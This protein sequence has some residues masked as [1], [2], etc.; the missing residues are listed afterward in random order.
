[1]GE[2]EKGR[3]GE[4]GFSAAETAAEE[5]PSPF[6]PF[7]HSPTLH[8]PSHSIKIAQI[9][10]R[11]DPGGS[12]DVVLALCE[13]LDRA[14]FDV[15][16]VT[17]PGSDSA[18]APPDVAGRV[19]V[20]VT[21]CAGLTREVSAWRDF[22]ALMSLYSYLRRLRPHVVHTH[23]SKAG[24]LGRLAAAW[25][26]IPVVHS[27]HGHLFY[28]YYGALGTELVV[29]AERMLAPYAG[30]IAVL[31]ET[32]RTEHLERGI[33]RMPQYEVVPSGIDLGRFTPDP[34]RRGRMRT[35][36]GLTDEFLIGWIGRFSEVKAPD[37]FI[38][39]CARVADRVDTARFVLAG[40]GELRDETEARAAKL[41]VAGRCQFLGRRD[42]IPALLNACDLLV[43]SSRNEGLGLAAI[44]AMACGV[45]V[46]ATDVGGLHE[47]L[48]DGPLAPPDDPE[49]LARRM[50][51]MINDT[52]R[53]KVLV[54]AG[55]E[56]ATAYGLDEMT[57]RFAAIYE[58]LACGC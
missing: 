16:L 57:E 13:R 23:T 37:V 11:L 38:D 10:T 12:A 28:G 6:P 51:A 46:V 19:G 45:P 33:G 52:S 36:L 32:S 1:M 18:A 39:A 34:T 48:P 43:L 25:C 47:L 53:R 4:L 5:Q 7:P 30:R 31:T 3:N 9:I 24:A 41:G 17:G 50:I 55:L 44:E 26:G 40:D 2:V 29:A 49:A 35:E 20:D 21:E 54:A 42:D 15:T 22:R 56:R 27:P 58:E 8:K 14:R